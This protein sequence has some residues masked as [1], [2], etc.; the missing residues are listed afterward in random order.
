MAEEKTVALITGASSGMGA[1]LAERLAADG[2]RVTLAARRRDRLAE[3]A[4]RV[5]AA[6]GEPLV[7]PTDVGRLDEVR[8][9]IERTTEA[10]GRIDVLFNGAGLFRTGLIEELPDED[11]EAQ[12]RVNLLAPIWVIKGVVPIMKRQNSGLIINV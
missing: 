4:A 10:F 9:M 7:C 2:A 8:A 12:I 1:A 5:R 3:V 6:G 11:I